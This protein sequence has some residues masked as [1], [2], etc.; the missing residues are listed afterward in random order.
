M[1]GAILL[2]LEVPDVVPE[3]NTELKMVK[4]KH[5]LG[6]SGHMKVGV[7][8]WGTCGGLRSWCF[9]RSW[10][11]STNFL[12]FF[13]NRNWKQPSWMLSTLFFFKKLPAIKTCKRT[14]SIKYN[15]YTQPC[16]FGIVDNFQ[17]VCHGGCDMF[18][19]IFERKTATLPGTVTRSTLAKT[20][21][22]GCGKIPKRLGEENSE[23]IGFHW[24]MIPLLI[25]FLFR[26]SGNNSVLST[27]V[28]VDW[29]Y[30]CSSHGWY[31]QQ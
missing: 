11:K 22:R 3:K 21:N 18:L 26:N 29:P 14:A 30:P 1:A 13:S 20:S 28:F 19:R 10:K 6:R 8:G 9:R 24:L 5:E 12:S 17:H 27:R 23:G 2:L 4:R 25:L 7:S 16:S 31:S 15:L